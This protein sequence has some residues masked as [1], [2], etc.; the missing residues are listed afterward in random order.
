MHHYIE[1]K[2][3]RAATGPPTTNKMGKRWVGVQLCI[4]ELPVAMTESDV[5]KCFFWR[6]ASTGQCDAGSV[7]E[8]RSRWQNL[9]WQ[10]AVHGHRFCLGRPQSMA[11]SGLEGSKT[12]ESVS[13]GRG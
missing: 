12:T 11:E 3:D 8:G 6:Q 2:E 4:G 1:V 5:E 13:E 10:A 9:F 7:W